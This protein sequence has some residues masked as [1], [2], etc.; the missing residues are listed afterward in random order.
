MATRCPDC[1]TSVIEEL[2]YCFGCFRHLAEP[3]EKESS[4][5]PKRSR[6]KG[7][8]RGSQPAEAEEHE[9]AAEELVDS[10]PKQSF[11]TWEPGQIPKGT[12][13]F[14]TAIQDSEWRRTS[15]RSDDH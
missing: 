5:E 4:A 7:L 15:R 9:E 14:G 8:K 6:F 13:I 12:L 1:G 10:A 2:S 3:L 11:L